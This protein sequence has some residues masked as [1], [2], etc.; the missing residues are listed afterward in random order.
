LAENVGHVAQRLKIRHVI[1]CRGS[2]VVSAMPLNFRLHVLLP[3]FCFAVLSFHPCPLPS[4]LPT[5]P[6]DVLHYNVSLQPDW[7]TKTLAG[8]ATLTL[9]LTENSSTFRLSTRELTINKVTLEHGHTLHFITDTV[10]AFTEITL[11]R[12]YRSDEKITVQLI[13]HTRHQNHCDP[14]QPGGSFGSGLRFFEPTAANPVKRK[15]VWTQSELYDCAFWFPCHT[16]ISD[17]STAELHVTVDSNLT[18]VS[19]GKQ[20]EK[21]RQPGGKH[22]FHFYHE[23]PVPAFLLGFAAGEYTDVVQQYDG[24]LLH[25]FCYPDETEAAKATVVSLPDMMRFLNR[26]TGYNYPFP[27]YTQVMV[28]N[29]PFPSLTGPRMCSIISD[30]MIDDYGTHNDFQYLWDGVEFNALAS[31]WFG[32]SILPKTVSDSWLAKSFAQ[33]Y[34]GRYTAHIH[35]EAEYLLWYHPWETGSVDGD[36]NSGIRF[37]VAPE[38]VKDEAAFA[39]SSYPKYKGALVLRLLSYELGETTFQKAVSKF[40]REFAFKPATT[41]DFEQTVN[42]V[43]NRNMHWFFEQWIY[44]AGQPVF[45]ISDSYNAALQQLTLRIVQTQQPD[46]ALRFAQTAFYRG[47]MD[48]EIDGK[49]MQIEL[50]PKA[51]NEFVIAC[52]AKPQWVNA[53]AGNV[54]PASKTHP[55]EVT[56]WLIQL[57]QSNDMAAQHAAM[58][59]LVQT[60]GSEN[61]EASAKAKIVAALRAV[62]AGKAYWRFRFMALGQ[63]RAIEKAPY[64]K[65]TE[66]LLLNLIATE[67]TWLKAAAITS[68]GLTADSAH[69]ALYIS[70]L[71]DSSDRVVNAAAIALGKTKSSKAW[72]ALNTLLKRPSW[73][74]Q[75][76]MH[77]LAGMAAL[78]DERTE[79][80]ALTALNDNLSPRWYLGNTWDY[81]VVATQTLATLGKT[82]KAFPL[83]HARF[84]I[85][86]QENNAD[87]IF[88][89]LLLIT[90]L[91]DERGKVAFDLLRKKYTNAPFFLSGVEFY[92]TQFNA[93]VSAK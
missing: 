4:E 88:Y 40:L 82:Q 93:S 3:V 13:Y 25:T 2:K 64:T 9:Q 29:Y 14:T 62:C 85:A 15:Q 38:N 46:T 42:R 72:H 80:V 47:R 1:L 44:N 6:I 60:A 81:P 78:G 55:K 11:P 84:W 7:R 74:S 65:Q 49:R 36:W 27:A 68:L 53:D 89:Q 17:L 71:T 90:T 76:L 37:P 21:T 50:L 70:C 57:E 10:Q 59:A 12:T 56:Q 31:Q 24:K 30:N 34:E 39:A 22:T 54:W 63:L 77:A 41:K 83:V 58:L 5:A 26:S 35:G 87:D 8:E 33:Y 91:A 19:G 69:A 86:V 48:V 75:S 73:K 79:A 16:A 43:S 28:Q 52:A 66:A 20:K 51:V 23:L 61:C 67:K 18:V 45:E 92:E 32:N